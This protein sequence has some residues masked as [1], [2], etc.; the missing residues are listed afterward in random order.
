MPGFALVV[1]VCEARNLRVYGLSGKSKE[2]E[3]ESGTT[4]ES[5]GKNIGNCAKCAPW[6]YFICK[7][8]ELGY[9]HTNFS[10]LLVEDPCRGGKE[11]YSQL[12]PSTRTPEETLRYKDPERVHVILSF[13]GAAF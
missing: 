10:K 7:V 5:Y 6:N 11:H 3:Q 2:N 9:L 8:R 13:L 4:A 12:F 1:S